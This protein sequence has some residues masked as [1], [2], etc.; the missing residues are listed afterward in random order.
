MSCVNYVLYILFSMVFQFC[1]LTNNGIQ[2]ILM[3]GDKLN[4][5]LGQ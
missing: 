5:L 1:Y 3:Y 2:K 4:I